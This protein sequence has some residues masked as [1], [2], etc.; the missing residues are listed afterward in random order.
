MTKSFMSMATPRGKLALLQSSLHPSCD[1]RTN[2]NEV[3]HTL[4]HSHFCHRLQQ[5]MLLHAKQ[6]VND[7]F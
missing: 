4:F 6:V 3:L 5:W 2:H 7:I 1:N